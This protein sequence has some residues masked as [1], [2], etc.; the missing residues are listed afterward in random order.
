MVPGPR[1]LSQKRSSAVLH[2]R[3]PDSVNPRCYRVGA[4]ASLGREELQDEIVG[5]DFWHVT[6]SQ[7]ARRS[8]AAPSRPKSEARVSV[9][10]THTDS[11]FAATITHKILRIGAAQLPGLVQQLTATDTLAV[12]TC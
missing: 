6:G 9:L 3:F 5:G 4:A 2:P 7:V 10:T 8:E 1:D 11:D 12:C